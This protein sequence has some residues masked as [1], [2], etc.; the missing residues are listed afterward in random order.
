MLGLSTFPRERGYCLDVTGMV[1]CVGNGCRC[2]AKTS[3]DG[4]LSDTKR[5]E[6]FVARVAQST[7]FCFT[8]GRSRATSCL[9]HDL[10][11]SLTTQQ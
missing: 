7:R 6:C 11:S 8:I 10:H 4:C 2:Q 9:P 3:K 5:M 1:Y